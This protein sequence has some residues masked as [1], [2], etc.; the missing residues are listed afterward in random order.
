MNN[1]L[2]ALDQS[3][4]A[5]GWAL[6]LNHD[7]IDYGVI[8]A[9]GY[10]DN[11]I[12]KMRNWLEH[13]IQEISLFEDSELNI[14]IEDIQVQNGNVLT[15]KTLARLQGVLINT[16]I[17]HNIPYKIFFSSEWKKTCGIKGKNRPEQKRNAQL[18]IKNKFNIDV[19]QDTCD[20]ICIGI[21]CLS[22]EKGKLNFK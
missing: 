7:L 17:K 18:F 3:T 11:K 21:H 16:I 19:I 8:K 20:A 6:F 2:L 10:E 9:E 1:Y 12:E 22:K 5:T 13:K 14:A 15:F 4:S